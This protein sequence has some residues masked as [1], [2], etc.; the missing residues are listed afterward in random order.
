M[1]PTRKH[2]H[3][4]VKH[5]YPTNTVCVRTQFTHTTRGKTHKH[6]IQTYSRFQLIHAPISTR[7]VMVLQT[8]SGSA[9]TWRERLKR[10]DAGY[11]RG[12]LKLAA[13]LRLECPHPGGH[14]ELWPSPTQPSI[15]PRSQGQIHDGNIL[16]KSNS[17]S[18]HPRKVCETFAL[19]V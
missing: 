15:L 11:S 12:A 7:G 16:E 19:M 8:S 4:F 6:E 17:D 2:K 10:A 1:T 18:T 5:T 3:V 13:T 14:Y 9:P